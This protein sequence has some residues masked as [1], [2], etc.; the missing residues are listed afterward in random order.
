MPH[1]RS[2]G[3]PKN[4]RETIPIELGFHTY[5]EGPESIEAMGKAKWQRFHAVDIPGEIERLQALYLSEHGLSAFQSQ[6]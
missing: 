3:S 4:D 2:F 6:K 1:V 5:Q